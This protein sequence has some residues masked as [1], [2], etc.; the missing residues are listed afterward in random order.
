[1]ALPAESFMSASLRRDAAGAD[2]A[3]IMAASIA[4]V[5]PKRCVADSVRVDKGVLRVDN[6]EIPLPTAGRILV[7]GGG[8]AGLA[9]AEALVETLGDRIADGV[10]AVKA[11]PA[12]RHVVGPIAIAAAAH[13]VPDAT[14]VDAARRLLT[15]LQS[16]TA[17]D[18][19]ICPISGGA[20][21]LLCAP[22]DEV[23]L[24]AL[25]SVVRQ[26]LHAG[27]TIEELNTVR[28]HLDRLKGGGLALA[29]A[30]ARVLALIV[31]D[32]PGDASP[33]A[34]ATVASGPTFGDPSTFADAQAVLERIADVP[35][36]VRNRIA[37]G[38]AGEVD[39]NPR[40]GA[41]P[42]RHVVHHCV[43]SNAT[44]RE[45]AADAARTAGYTVEALPPLHGDA[46]AVGIA[47]GQRLSTQAPG[48]LALGGGET[49]VTVTGSG[50][51]G[52]NQELALAAVPVMLG[53]HDGILATLATDG[54]D[55]PTDAAGAVVRGNT[56]PRAL[57]R[58][59]DP[60]QSL[61]NNDAYGFF[62]PLG[63][64]IQTG[65][66]GTNV[67]DLVFALTEKA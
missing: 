51:G 64:L 34:L 31:S 38:V 54:E 43:A 48:V 46:R 5:D 27:A 8:K 57:E 20:S 16:S 56:L 52:R 30:P 18:L 37:R 26:L 62:E 50:R 45:A 24:E 22:P 42:L 25:Q 2:L 28:K 7:A 13:P 55:G 41:D 9:M 19:V 60:L 14:S 49:T 67:C 47:I 65:P 36:A 39:D 12:A 58:G 40:P 53:L 15:L 1:M 23:P 17:D 63:D 4:A 59:L 21:A 11:K 32:V 66:T 29:A 3:A 35:A 6:A 10:V 61:D 44:A 33:D